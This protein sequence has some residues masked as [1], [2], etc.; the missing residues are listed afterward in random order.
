MPHHDLIVLTNSGVFWKWRIVHALKVCKSTTVRP[1][2]I[3]AVHAAVHT[4][5]LTRPLHWQGTPV[6]ARTRR[7]QPTEPSARRLRSPEFAEAPRRR[8]TQTPLPVLVR[9]SE[10]PGPPTRRVTAI[11]PDLTRNPRSP[12][13]SQISR[14]SGAGSHPRFAG[15]RRD[16]EFTPTTTPDLLGIGGPS[17]S[18]SPICR[19]RGST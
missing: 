2:G 6:P 1:R 3:S 5:G 8:C 13:P 9:G 7:V 12:S 19:N 16:R 15:D 18:P 17:P 4:S 10:S 14:G 11:V